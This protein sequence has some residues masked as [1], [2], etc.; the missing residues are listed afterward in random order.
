[1]SELIV[2]QAYI[3]EMDAQ[4]ESCRTNLELKF[5]AAYGVVEGMSKFKAIL[6]LKRRVVESEF[7]P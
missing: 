3:D 5:V 1:M 6:D 2:N 7:A 4:A